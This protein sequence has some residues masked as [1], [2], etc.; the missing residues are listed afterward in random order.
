[1]ARSQEDLLAEILEE[2]RRRKFTDEMVAELLREFGIL[3]LVFVPL[4]LIFA[5]MEYPGAAIPWQY[6]GLAVVG[7]LASIAVGIWLERGT[8]R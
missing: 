7:G 6:V 1:L 8:L 4:D 5:R 3:V 2:L